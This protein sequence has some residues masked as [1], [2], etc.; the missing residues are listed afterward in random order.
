MGVYV[1]ES[2]HGP[3]IKVGHYKGSNAWRRIAPNRGFYSTKYPMELEEKVGPADFI[4]RLWFPN[5]GT[6]DESYLHTRL[7]D[8]RIV[9][10]WYRATALARINQIIT[11]D[12]AAH[13]CNFVEA[14][15]FKPE[16]TIGER[17][18]QKKK[19]KPS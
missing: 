1:F 12:N 15:N 8:L 6:K 13:L 10:E 14:M 2:K 5:L 7:G 11:C 17:I 18:I 9:G 16:L 3:Y 19:S 4:L